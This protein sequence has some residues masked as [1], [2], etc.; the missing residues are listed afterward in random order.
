MLTHERVSAHFSLMRTSL[1]AIHSYTCWKIVLFCSSTRILSSKCSFCPYF[2]WL[3]TDFPGRWIGRGPIAWMH[4]ELWMA[5]TVKCSAT[6]NF[7]TSVLDELLQL[8]NKV[9]PPI[10]SYIFIPK[11]QVPEILAILL[12][13]PCIIKC[14]LNNLYSPPYESSVE[15]IQT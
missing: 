2:P 4:T 5:L 7:P 15:T 3:T 10:C 8:L 1:Q 12:A 6:N 9:L 11:L 14:N 13:R